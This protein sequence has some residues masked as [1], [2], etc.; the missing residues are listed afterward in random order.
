V[1]FG[2][3]SDRVTGYMGLRFE[4]GGHREILPVLDPTHDG[5]EFSIT[6]K[7]RETRDDVDHIR[8]R[9]GVIA[10]HDEIKVGETNLLPATGSSQGP[11]IQGVIAQA[12]PSY[13]IEP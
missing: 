10:Q 4:Y 3:K 8:H 5:L 1:V 2:E 7:I 11:S 6:S 12:F 13:A 9:F